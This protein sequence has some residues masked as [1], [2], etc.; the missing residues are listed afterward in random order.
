VAAAGADWI[1]QAQKRSAGP[2]SW[3]MLPWNERVALELLRAEAD[4]LVKTSRSGRKQDVIDH[5]ASNATQA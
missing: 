3:N 1:E 2:F 5:R 4:G